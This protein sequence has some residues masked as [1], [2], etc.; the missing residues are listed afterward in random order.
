MEWKILHALLL[1]PPH[2][3]VCSNMKPHTAYIRVAAALG[4]SLALGLSGCAGKAPVPGGTED[5]NKQ[6][7]SSV[8]DMQARL[9]SLSPGMPEDQAMLGLCEKKE[10]FSRLD[11]REIR[12]ALLGG[13]NVLFSAGQTGDDSALIRTLYGYKLAYKST[14]KR[15]GFSS[16]I[17]IQTNETGFNYTIRLIFRDGV[18]FE[19]PILSG[20]IVNETTSGTLFDFITPGTIINKA[21]PD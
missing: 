5:V 16:P 6:C 17:R 2:S 11:R 18:L 8:S 10:E 9:L 1:L 15:H 14:K 3:K 7:F 20:G 19:R 13:D 12:V 21:I 4:L